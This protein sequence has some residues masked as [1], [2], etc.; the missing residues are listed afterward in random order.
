MT[1]GAGAVHYGPGEKANRSGLYRATSREKADIALS[2]GDRFPPLEDRG[3]RWILVQPTEPAPTS[4][5]LYELKADPGAAIEAR[6]SAAY[7]A[8]LNGLIMAARTAATTP[9]LPTARHLRAQRDLR[10]AVDHYD[11]LI[12]GY[13]VETSVEVEGPFA[14]TDGFAE[15][16]FAVTDV[17]AETVESGKVTAD[18][19]HEWVG[20]PATAERSADAEETASE[21][22]SKPRGFLDRAL[23]RRDEP[24]A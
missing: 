5:E 24:P 18:E 20:Q 7:Q 1:E 6:N 15:R 2:A 14:V 17:F 13:D 11:Q 4:E 3:A 16:P 21:E 8:A 12:A 10:H 22:P 23:G 19:L 9:E